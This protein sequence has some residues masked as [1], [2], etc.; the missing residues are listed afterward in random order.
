MPRVSPDN[1]ETLLYVLNHNAAP[2]TVGL[3][4]GAFTDLLSSG[5]RC[6]G[7]VELPGYG[8]RILAGPDAAPSRGTTKS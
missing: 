7:S 6:A 5:E 2:V 8:V 3:P 1:S 4:P